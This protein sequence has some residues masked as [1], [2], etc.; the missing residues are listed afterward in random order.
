MY[1]VGNVSFVFGLCAGT[2]DVSKKEDMGGGIVYVVGGG[3]RG[4]R[5][6]RL[7]AVVAHRYVV[8]CHL[9]QRAIRRPN[10]C[11][12]SQHG[13]RGWAAGVTCARSEERE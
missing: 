9:A 2:E 4:R 12:H 7:P 10:P 3:E 6:T 8:T 13:E 11:A 1:L 5:V